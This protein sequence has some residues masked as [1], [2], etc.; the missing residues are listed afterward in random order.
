MLNIADFCMIFTATI[1]SCLSLLPT[2]TVHHRGFPNAALTNT[3]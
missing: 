3:F 1:S 2:V